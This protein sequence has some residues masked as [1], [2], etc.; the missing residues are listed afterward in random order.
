M[1]VRKQQTIGNVRAMNICIE[2]CHSE[3]QE[4]G[5]LEHMTI[6]IIRGSDCKIDDFI[7]QEVLHFICNTEKMHF[8]SVG[9]RPT[10]GSHGA[11]PYFNIQHNR[12]AAILALGW[13][14]QWEMDVLDAAAGR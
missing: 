3:P 13:S 1:S 12:M 9:G 5:S 14:G 8:E 4:Q 10:S 2:C 7:P 11:M 6:C